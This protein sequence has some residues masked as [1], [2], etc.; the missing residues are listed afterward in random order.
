MC[1]AIASLIVLTNPDVAAAQAVPRIFNEVAIAPQFGENVPLDLPFVDADGRSV[2]LSELF[3]D[4]PVILH[5]VY[6]ECPMLCKLSSDGLLRALSTLVAKTGRGFFDRHGQLRSA[7]GTGAFGPRARSGDRAL[8][9]RGRGERLADFSPAT[10]RPSPSCAR[11]SAFATRLTTRHRPVRAR[12]RRLHPDA[13]RHAFSLFE[14]RR[15]LA[16]RLAAGAGRSIRRQSRH[17]GRP[18]A[19]DVLHVRPI[20]G[21]YGLAIMT[22]VRIAGIATVG[23]MGLA[24]FTMLR[25]ERR[26]QVRLSA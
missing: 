14:R 12:V 13:R 4:R 18:G 6:Y 26:C 11:P 22:A 8:R 1:C 19:A 7:R 25:R 23:G 9:A 17:R 3:S 2:R 10:K 16:A 5:L 20:T 24:I 21:K 15:V